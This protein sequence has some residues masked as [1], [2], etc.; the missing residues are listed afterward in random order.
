MCGVIV[1][2][3][4]GEEGGGGG[5]GG[6]WGGGGVAH[7]G[8]PLSL[9]KQGLFCLCCCSDPLLTP[10]VEQCSAWGCTATNSLTRLIRVCKKNYE[11]TFGSFGVHF[12]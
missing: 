6:G 11:T 5:R 9:L 3:S 1:A 8:V 2:G 12:Y 4:G 7:T 10:Y